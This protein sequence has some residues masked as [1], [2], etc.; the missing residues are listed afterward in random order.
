M[1]FAF[2][3]RTAGRR[4]SLCFREVCDVQSI[5]KSSW[6]LSLPASLKLRS[7]ELKVDFREPNVRRIFSSQLSWVAEDSGPSVGF[8]TEE[9]YFDE[10][11]FGIEDPI[12]V[13]VFQNACL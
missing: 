1:D 5:P 2:L 13:F 6:N 8:L 7:T 11:R 3:M 4:D 10:V 9:M 12:L